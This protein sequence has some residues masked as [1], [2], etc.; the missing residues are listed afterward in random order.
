MH[1]GARRQP[2]GTQ[3]KNA[4][5]GADPGGVRVSEAQNRVILGGAEWGPTCTEYRFAG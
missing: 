2:Q 3:G 1:E 5:R 4:E